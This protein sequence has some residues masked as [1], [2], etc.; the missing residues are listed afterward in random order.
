MLHLRWKQAAQHRLT[1]Y[2]VHC[3]ELV[4]KV[5]PLGPLCP[6][7]D[8]RLD[9]DPGAR[10]WEE[11]KRLCT[12]CWA[13]QNTRGQWVQNSKRRQGPRMPVRFQG[14]MVEAGGRIFRPVGSVD[15]DA[16]YVRQA[17]FVRYTTQ[18]VERVE[19]ALRSQEE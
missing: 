19:H 5:A 8:A 10:P 2:L 18:L 7:C 14:T 15:C 6:F 17:V 4:G 16:Q 9:G 11:D 12:N 13:V 3:G 1:W